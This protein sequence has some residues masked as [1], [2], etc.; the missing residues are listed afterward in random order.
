MHILNMICVTSR[1]MGEFQQNYYIFSSLIYFI[2]EL[3]G[4]FEF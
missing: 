1:L 4:F 3:L 2:A